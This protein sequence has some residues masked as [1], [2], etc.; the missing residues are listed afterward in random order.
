MTLE[1]R[2]CRSA[3]ND[4]LTSSLKTWP[5][6]CWDTI[7]KGKN[8]PTLCTSVVNDLLAAGFDAGIE[9]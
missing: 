6:N 1:L 2:S 8:L 5:Y 9:C 3:Y 4:E 7:L